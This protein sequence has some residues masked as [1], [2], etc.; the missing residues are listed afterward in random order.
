MHIVTPY[1]DFYT[2][3]IEYLCVDT[4]NGKEGFLIGALPRIAVLSAGCID[5]KT[6][7]LELKAY[8]GA[9]IVCVSADGITVLTEKC[10][11]DGDEEDDGFAVSE[12]TDAKASE[13]KAAKAQLAARIKRMRESADGDKL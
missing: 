10:R 6:S 8:C 13:Y 2:G 9:G 3:D 1:S 12:Y 5:I 7:V 4:P 11:F